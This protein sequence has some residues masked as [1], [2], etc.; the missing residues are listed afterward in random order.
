MDKF[1]N[2]VKADGQNGAKLVICKSWK[3]FPLEIKFIDL[4]KLGIIFC[5][6]YKM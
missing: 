1:G 4:K 2:Q 5:Y 3:A 6:I